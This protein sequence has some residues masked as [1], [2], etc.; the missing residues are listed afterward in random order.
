MR[1]GLLMGRATQ[2][3]AARSWCPAV[4]EQAEG[5]VPSLRAAALLVG[6]PWVVVNDVWSERW[7]GNWELVLQ[8]VGEHAGEVPMVLALLLLVLVLLAY[9]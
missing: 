7:R 5:L 2:R 3:V 8:V 9:R 4:E 6:P 1:A